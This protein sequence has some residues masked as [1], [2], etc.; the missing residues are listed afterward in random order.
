MAETFGFREATVFI[1][2]P[3]GDDF[4]AH[5]T[6]G[7]DPIIDRRVLETIIPGEVFA[8][9]F[10]ERFQIGDS[11]FIDH[12]QYDMGRREVEKYF[13]APDLGPRRPG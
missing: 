8:A 6:V 7:Q 13:P 5:A 9:L 12:R 1:R 11:Y 2:E 4:R 10:Q 3:N